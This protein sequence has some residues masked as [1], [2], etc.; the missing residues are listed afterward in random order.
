MTCVLQ[1]EWG[2]EDAALVEA[3]PGVAVF[4]AVFGMPF[5]ETSHTPLIVITGA[6]AGTLDS[7]GV[8]AAAEGAACAAPAL[9]EGGFGDV[10]PVCATAMTAQ[11]MI[12]RTGIKELERIKNASKRIKG[13]HSMLAHE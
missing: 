10:S 3:F 5:S 8:D 13:E 7:A 6:F 12:N 9:G 4:G 2:V 1:S 11:L